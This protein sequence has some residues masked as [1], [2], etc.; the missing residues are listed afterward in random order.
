MRAVVKGF[1]CVASVL[2]V[3]VVAGC[4]ARPTQAPV[5]QAMKLGSA[6]GALATACGRSYRASSF[7]RHPRRVR[8]IDAHAKP[9]ARALLSVYRRDPRWIY[10]GQ[11][12][13]QIARDA[14]SLTRD[15][16]LGRTAS[17]LARGTRG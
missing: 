16:G 17:I 13:E 2:L 8:G 14:I 5:P 15:C 4:G 1:L 9:D 7:G 3:A 11:T 6:T 12:V 10:L